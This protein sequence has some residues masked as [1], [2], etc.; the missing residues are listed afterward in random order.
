[1][2]KKELEAFAKNAEMNRTGFYACGSLA[3]QPIFSAYH[4]R[5]ERALSSTIFR[6][7]LLR[8]FMRHM[9]LFI[10]SLIIFTKSILVFAH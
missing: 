4:K 1:M 6:N 7:G 9:V 3:K 5:S 2:N 10:Q 8:L